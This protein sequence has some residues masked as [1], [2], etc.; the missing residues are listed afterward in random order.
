MQPSLSGLF[1]ITAHG[2]LQ[3]QRKEA[4]LSQLRTLHCKLS[5]GIP[6]CTQPRQLHSCWRLCS[7]F[8]L[9]DDESNCRALVASSP[10]N[11]DTVVCLIT[12]CGHERDNSS[13]ICPEASGQ[14][15][16]LCE[17]FDLTVAV[18]FSYLQMA[19]AFHS[20]ALSSDLAR[21]LIL[22]LTST[23][24]LKAGVGASDPT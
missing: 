20:L 24:T 9:T 23:N 22:T 17:S 19:T 3:L 5:S 6:G 21:S 11:P 7:V 13:G 8:L 16:L 1:P 14:T 10:C 4:S 15:S 12:E 2:S 18:A